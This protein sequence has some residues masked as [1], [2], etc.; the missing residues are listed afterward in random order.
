VSA[1]LKEDQKLRRIIKVY[2]VESGVIVTLTHAGIEFKIPKTKL[3]VSMP[4]TKAV[5]SC[6]TPSN[7]PSKFEGRPLDFLK[8]QATEVVKRAVKRATK[9]KL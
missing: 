6:L 2:G 8:T 7:L 9:E 3:G 4:W 5:E 1:V